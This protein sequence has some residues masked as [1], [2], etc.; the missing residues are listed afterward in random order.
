MKISRVHDNWVFIMLD[1]AAKGRKEALK[2]L[3]WLENRISKIPTIAGWICESKHCFKKM[4]DVL[5]RLGAV[6]YAEDD[7]SYYFKKEI[8]HGVFA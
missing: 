1:D 3:R 4:H 6:R 2:N 7:E 5:R 8:K